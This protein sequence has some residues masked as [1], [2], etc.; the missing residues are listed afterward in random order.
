VTTN[1]ELMAVLIPLGSQIYAAN[2]AVKD[3]TALV[4]DDE[5]GVLWRELCDDVN[6]L[7][8]HFGLFVEYL[9][10]DAVGS[11]GD[12]AQEELLKFVHRVGLDASLAL[13]GQS[14]RRHLGVV[15]TGGSDDK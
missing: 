1:K 9:L 2:A 13:V 5:A 4:I 14:M 10:Q 8:A 15:K 12:S 6:Q 3:A 11:E 7:R